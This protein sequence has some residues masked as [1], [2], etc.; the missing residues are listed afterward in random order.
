VVS[1][2]GAAIEDSGDGGEQDVTP[3]EEGGALV[4]VGKA[5]DHGGDEQG[6]SAAN[7]AFEEVLDPTAEEDFFRERDA[8]EGG[9]PRGDEEPGMVNV[10]MEV[11][12]AEREAEG[13]GDGEVKK[14]LAEASGPVALAEA[15]VEADGSEAADSEEGVEA[16]IEE[17]ELA[18]EGEFVGPGGFEPAE[19]DGEAERDEDEEVEEVATLSRVEPGGEGFESDEQDG[20]E[21]VNEEPAECETVRAEGD[22][23]VRQ[24]E[25]GGKGKAEGG[26]QRLRGPDAAVAGKGEGEERY[27]EK[28]QGHSR[29]EDGERQGHVVIVAGE[30]GRGAVRTIR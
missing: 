1:A 3:V 22:D 18:E 16:R 4:E 20:R 28:R 17:S 25:N 30:R 7:T 10:A 24:D 9:E 23:A 21:E 14:K 19:V 15:E 26:G 11:E 8:D 5:K 13:D 27:E 6:G 2:P 29:W 12:E